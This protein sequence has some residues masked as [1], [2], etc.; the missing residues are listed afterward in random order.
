MFETYLHRAK[1]LGS[2]HA[3]VK[4]WIMQRMSAIA[5]IPLSLWAIYMLLSLI[6]A[7][8]EQVYSWFSSPWKTTLTLLFI[9]T[10]FYH[11][12]LG[13][14]VIWE[15]YI[16]SSLFRGICIM[17]TRF[18]SIGLGV[19]SIICILKMYFSPSPLFCNASSTLTP[20]R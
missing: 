16:P 4:F 9:S 1:G 3:G 7:P 12:A 8:F 19:L 14:Q 17:C 10:M 5:L 6:S 15:D 13:M 18:L 11:G 20:Y 2:S